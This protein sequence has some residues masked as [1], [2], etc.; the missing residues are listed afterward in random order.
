MF[1]DLKHAWR[2]LFRSPAI[3][4][5]AVVTLALGIGA[6]TAIFS[7]VYALLLKPLPFRDPDRLIYVHDTFPA[8]ANAS[9]S[10]KKFVAL[11]D[12][13]RTLDA[14]AATSSGILT[15]TG[16]GEPQ[17]IVTP[18]VSADFFK[19]LGVPP[20]A[21]RGFTSADDVPNAA[22]VIVLTYGL[23]QRAFGGNPR[24]V[25]EAVA[26]N[27]IERTIV[28]VMP[29]GFLYPSNA[30]AWIPLA[31]QPSQ[32]ETNGLRLIGR[33]RT[34]V[35]LQQ[36][37][38]DLDAVTAVF[39][40]DNGAAPRHPR[41]SAARF[42]VADQSPDAARPSRRGAARAAGR[43]RQRRQHAAGPQHLQVAGVRDS[44]RDRST[45]GADPPA[46]AHRERAAVGGRRRRRRA[47]GRVAR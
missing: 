47:R 24:V 14:F 43:V 37:T 40:K 23:W 30:E 12:G 28:G 29:A 39:N 2:S 20:L 26:A 36:A 9:V 34:G 32:Q 27:G 41:L 1:Y 21:G 16:H 44:R 38:Q 22:P 4:I 3:T 25:G 35:T 18:R 42:S 5:T 11:R 17:R 45:A 8:V 10:W 13:N 33:V 46:A 19:V 31:L 7:I 6:N 15:I